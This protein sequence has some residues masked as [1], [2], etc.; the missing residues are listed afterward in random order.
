[1]MLTGHNLRRSRV[2]HRQIT[3]DLLLG[4]M[5]L[6]TIAVLV[7]A[8]IIQGPAAMIITGMAP[9]TGGQFT[10]QEIPGGVIRICQE[11]M[12]S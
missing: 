11:G 10:M 12:L 9:D 2:S 3:M 1:M 8:G 4:L 7:I 5:V 6:I